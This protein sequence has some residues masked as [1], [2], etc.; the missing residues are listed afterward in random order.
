MS[1]IAGLRNP[2]HLTGVS[3]KSFR[4]GAPGRADLTSDRRAPNRGLPT[5]TPACGRSPVDRRA[6]LAA[7]VGLR[8]RRPSREDEGRTPR[9]RLP[10]AGAA[11]RGTRHRAPPAARPARCG[12]RKLR[13]RRQAPRTWNRRV[14]L[15]VEGAALARRRHVL[16]QTKAPAPRSVR[17]WRRRRAPRALN[18]GLGRRWP[19]GRPEK[20]R[21]ASGCS[22]PYGL[23]P[24]RCRG[25]RR[26]RDLLRVLVG[27]GTTATGDSA[28]AAFPASWR[29]AGRRA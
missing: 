22:A 3:S 29:T 28:T 11:P 14:E 9:S 6:A 13:R 15:A 5:S 18:R 4:R 21:N 23:T 17:A 20:R 2:V 1:T 16:H 19:R 24:P 8:R 10:A 26:G 27:A 25:T 12:G 7:P